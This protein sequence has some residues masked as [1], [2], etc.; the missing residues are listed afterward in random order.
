MGCSEG[1]REVQQPGQAP[2]SLLYF[3]P[4][5]LN[6][7]THSF[8]LHGLEPSSLYHVQ[9]VAASQAMDRQQYKPHLTL[10]LGKENGA[11]SGKAVGRANPK[12]CHV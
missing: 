1:L 5:S 8:V 4:L 11:W 6:A 2:L 9:L 3:Q 12:G 10:T 7:S